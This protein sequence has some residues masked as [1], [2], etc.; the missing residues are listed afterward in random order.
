[1]N[2]GLRA[3][4]QNS[5][6]LKISFSWEQNP[7]TGVL[8]SFA[9]GLGVEPRVSAFREQRATITPPGTNIVILPETG[10]VWQLIDCTTL[11]TIKS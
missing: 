9:A 10:S 2:T 7:Q 8:Q 3:L 4:T 6:T 5:P 11:C 1:M